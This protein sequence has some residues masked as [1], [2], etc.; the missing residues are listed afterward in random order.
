GGGTDMPL[1]GSVSGHQRRAVSER[2]VGG[3]SIDICFQDRSFGTAFNEADRGA[4]DALGCIV[5]ASEP[6]QG[7]VVSVPRWNDRAEVVVKG[8]LSD[9]NPGET[10]AVI[11]CGAFPNLMKGRVRL[12][13]VANARLGCARIVLGGNEY[14]IR[15]VGVERTEA[16]IVRL[17]G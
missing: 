12:I 6:E 1:A 2:G 16:N 11:G 7:C 3:V 13:R 10:C 15:I 5:G 4:V 8:I 17:G 14:G 9:R